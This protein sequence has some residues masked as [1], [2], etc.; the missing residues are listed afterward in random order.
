MV[1]VLQA[2]EELGMVRFASN[3]IPSSHDWLQSLGYEGYLDYDISWYNSNLLS[4]S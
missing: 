3:G 4:K 1:E 2:I